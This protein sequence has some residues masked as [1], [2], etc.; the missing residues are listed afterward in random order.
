MILLVDNY[1][2]FVFNLARYL[3]RLGCATRVVRNDAIGPREIAALG[4]EAVVLSPGPCTP[5]EAG[6]SLEVVRHLAPKIP[7]L[8]ICL[9]HQAIGAAFGAS[10]VRAAEPVHGR[11][12]E[13]FHDGQSVFAGLPSPI[14]A[15][16]YHSLVVECQS[17]PAELQVTAWTA[18]GTIMALAHRELPVVGLQFHPESILTD[19]G[20]DLLAAF[21]RLAGIPVSADVP[22]I[23]D[24][25][26]EPAVTSPPPP[27]APVTF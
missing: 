13:I 8:G 9:G 22:R 24:E 19:V 27:T 14:V 15:C 3:E 16:R 7:I 6:C 1:D 18:D 4:P 21:L 23:D 17:L 12:S 26:D 5:A 25:R 2:S 11:T 10:I 20:Y